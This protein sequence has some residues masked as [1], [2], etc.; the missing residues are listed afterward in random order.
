MGSR[1]GSQDVVRNVGVGSYNQNLQE[2][3]S[4]HNVCNCIAIPLLFNDVNI[5][6]YPQPD[7][8]RFATINARSLRNKTAVFTDHIVE[9][10]IDVCVVTE[11]WLKNKD[12]PSI[13]GICQSGYLFKSFPRQ[14]NRMG[15]GTGVMFKSGLNVSLSRGEDLQSFEYSE[16]KF[17]IAGYSIKLIAVYRPPYSMA[18]PVLP[19]KFFDEFSSYLED[20]IL[21]PE[22]LLITGDF[23][24]H[25]DDTGNTNTIKLN[26]MLE[27]FGL[28]QHVSIPTHSSNH[29]LDLLITRSTTDI[30]ISSIESTLYLS[31]HCFIECELS[32]PRPLHSKKEISYREMKKINID[33]FKADLRCLDRRCE[34]MANL[35]ELTHCYDNVLSR[36]LNTHAPVRRKLLKVKRLTPWY[37]DELRELKVRRRSFERKMRKTKLQ[38]DWIAYRRICNKYC[39]LLNKARSEYYTTLINDSSNDHKKLYRIVNSLCDVPR[40]DP[41]PPHNNLGQLAN[42][43]NEYFFRK[44]ELIRENVDS[45]VV[46]SPLVEYRNP[47]IKLASFEILSFEDIHDVIMQL[48]SASCKLDPIPS[49]LVKRCSLELIPFITKIVN[50]SLQEG[51]VPD[52]WKIALLKPLLKKTNMEPIFEN[53]RPVSNL[54]FLSKITERAAANQLLRHCENN[55]PLPTCQSGFRKYHSTET[56]LLKVQNDILLSMDRQEICFL[57]LLD[58]SSAF[59][60][61]D[62]KTII[63]VLEYQFGVTDKALEWIKSFLSNR[64]QRVDLNNNFSEVCDVKYGV[65]QGSCLGPILFL[66]YVSQLYDII[67]RHLPSSHGYADDTQLYVSFRPDCVNQRSTLSALEECISDVRAWLVSH[68]LMFK[69]SKTEFL[70]IGTPQQLSKID[71]GP[72][73]VGGVLIQPVDS[74]RNLGSWFDKHM[75]MSVHVGKMCSKAFGGL[76]KIRQI[77]K[78]LS[79][80]TTKTLIHAFVTSHVDYCNALLT[81]IP[82]YQVQRIQRVLNAAARLI[83]HCP[84]FSHIT[85]VLIELHWLPVKY[86]VEFKIALLVYKALNNMAPVYITEMLIPKPSSDRWSLRSDDQDLLYIPI[87]NCKTLGDRSFA[88]VAPQLW[89]SL[90]LNVRNSVNISAFKRHLKTFL[91]KKAFNL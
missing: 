6:F 86:R 42:R 77:R 52:H 88:H 17:L 38:V 4:G 64:K 44:I 35:D 20:I 61:I 14:S 39:Y 7:L 84:R 63:E 79:V 76:Y 40:E 1:S 69:D 30:N 82:Q 85:P 60:T 24:F 53:F 15:G 37:N 49:W 81:G 74:L 54:L 27:T 89:N 55:A 13:A 50:L 51:L 45:I 73:N 21:C 10:N 43:F 9:Q 57:V 87:T 72:V 32:I 70:I 41:L 91:F 66:L 90:P 18:H 56:A 78:Y 36:I 83:H 59:D 80:D 3:P 65:P 71:I 23:N 26:E 48:S 11:T 46:E 16:W 25:L 75:S 31:D 12:T 5:A 33:D 62:H 22:I 2:G 19:G 47:E 29:I 28:K 58:L 68:K 34:N 67:D 8:L